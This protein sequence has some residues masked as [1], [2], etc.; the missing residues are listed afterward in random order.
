MPLGAINYLMIAVGA[1]VIAGSY[2]GMYLERA[3]DG[4][5]ALYISP[6]TLT[7]SYIWIIFALLY[8]SK[9]KRNAT[10]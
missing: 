6:F 8:R 10:I 1:L 9:K 4:F 2:F 3:V 5:F 7:G